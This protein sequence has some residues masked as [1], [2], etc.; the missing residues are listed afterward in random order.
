MVVTIDA[1]EHL[2]GAVR[3]HHERIDGAGYPDRLAGDAIPLV[4]RLVTVADCFNAMIG[5]R[6]YRDPLPPSAAIA[7]LRRN[8][9]S[10]FDP[11]VVRAMLAVLYSE[12][13]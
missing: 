7:E 13:T 3:S 9:G 4:A 8:S 5:R 10:Q 2:R 12:S 6:P 11:D 1:L